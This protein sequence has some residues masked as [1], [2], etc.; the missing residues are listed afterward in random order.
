MK[1]LIIG[2]G[3][4]GNEYE[5]TRHNIGFEVANTLA[6]LYDFNFTLGRHAYKGEFKLKGHLITVIKPTTYMN[7][8]GKALRYWMQQLNITITNII[9]V[10]DD[11]DLP[12]GKLRMRKKGSAGGHNGMRDIEATLTTPEYARLRMGIGNNFQ[13][14]KQVQ[15]VLG[16]WTEAE[17]A[18]V[19]IAIEQAC[20][21]LTAFVTEGI[22]QAMT[23]FNN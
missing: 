19:N 12:L 13:Q 4:I 2:L 11:K 9:V 14:G 21:A 7:L 23:K 18:E 15:F 1:F 8:S 6:K 10:V 17:K 22:D 5:G 3:N 16:K 20:Q